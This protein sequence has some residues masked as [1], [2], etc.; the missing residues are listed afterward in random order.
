MQDFPAEIFLQRPSIVK[1]NSE[2]PYQIFYIEYLILKSVFNIACKYLWQHRGVT[3]WWPHNG[4]H[5]MV[6]VA[7]VKMISCHSGS[8]NKTAICNWVSL[9]SREVLKASNGLLSWEDVVSVIACLSKVLGWV[10]HDI[11]LGAALAIVD[12]VKES[13]RASV[14]C[15]LI[16]LLLNIH[17]V[18][19]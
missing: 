6:T 3:C 19:F 11:S 16:Y 13:W 1:V 9:I 8:L 2:M 14:K 7:T 4:T 10:L 17:V 5:R 12:F 18:C 15:S